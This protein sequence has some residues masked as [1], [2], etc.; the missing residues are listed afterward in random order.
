[1]Q[2][3]PRKSDSSKKLE[4]LGLCGISPQIA[5]ESNTDHNQAITEFNGNEVAPIGRGLEFRLGVGSRTRAIMAQGGNEILAILRG[6]RKTP[7]KKPATRL[8]RI[9]KLPPPEKYSPREG[10]DKTDTESK[11][12]WAIQE[13]I[14]EFGLSADW[15]NAQRTIRA[16]SVANPDWSIALE[17]AYQHWF[18]GARQV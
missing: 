8:A 15:E 13:E 16:A 4:R 7:L 6:M 17:C 2:T 1:M 5:L 11:T 3:A 12:L 9:G 18:K 10:T 14:R